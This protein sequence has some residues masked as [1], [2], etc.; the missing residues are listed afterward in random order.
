MRTVELKLLRIFMLNGKRKTEKKIHDMLSRT[1]KQHIKMN[2]IYGLE[3]WNQRELLLLLAFL[4][5]CK[6]WA[7]HVLKHSIFISHV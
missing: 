7:I 1:E 6:V 2:L 5:Y 3:W 4:Y